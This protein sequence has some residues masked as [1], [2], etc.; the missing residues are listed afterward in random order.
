MKYLPVLL[1]VVLVVAAILVYDALRKPEPTGYAG[2]GLHD[3]PGPGPSA[4]APATA[5]GSLAG[6]GDEAWREVY[7]S[8]LARLEKEVA[9]RAAPAAVGGGGVV[10]EGD[11]SSSD[12]SSLLGAEDLPLLEE[13]EDAETASSRFTEKQL[14]TFRALLETVEQQ[15]TAD[16]A[17]QGVDRLIDRAGVQLTD[18]QKEAVATATLTHFQK[19]RDLRGQAGAAE[20]RRALFQTAMDDYRRTLETIVPASDADALVGQLSGRRTRGGGGAPGGA[21]FGRGGGRAG[22]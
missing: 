17:R 3:R 16:R 10:P 15:R 8:R 5:A 20:D 7:E 21:G 13:G 4:A 11:E 19:L 9:S 14:R 22:R 6:R 1:N 2:V 12:L 18:A